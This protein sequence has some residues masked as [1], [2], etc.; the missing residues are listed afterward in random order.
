MCSDWPACVTLF[1]KDRLDVSMLNPFLVVGSQNSGIS[2][3]S[4]FF[5][6]SRKYSIWS[7]FFAAEIDSYWLSRMKV[8][9]FSRSSLWSVLLGFSCH[10]NHHWHLVISLSLNRFYLNLR[11]WV[12]LFGSNSLLPSRLSRNMSLAHI[13]PCHCDTQKAH[14]VASLIFEMSIVLLIRL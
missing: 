3:L 6:R 10:L 9:S 7:V 2:L 5:G 11:N 13:T 4:E 12:S 1:T 14:R 8:F